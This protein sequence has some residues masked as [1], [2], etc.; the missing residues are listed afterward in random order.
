MIKNKEIA[1]NLSKLMLDMAARP[2]ES[3]YEVQEKCT[4]E[5]FKNYR[6]GVASLLATVATE[7][8]NPLYR[9]HPEV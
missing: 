5:E 6:R 7:V 9:E 8:L 1:Q 2:N 4:E 3:L